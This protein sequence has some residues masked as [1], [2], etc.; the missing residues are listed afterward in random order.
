MTSGSAMVNQA[1][2]GRNGGRRFRHAQ[3][4]VGGEGGAGMEGNGISTLLR[5]GHEE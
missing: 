3:E 4:E 5:R 2:M 1:E